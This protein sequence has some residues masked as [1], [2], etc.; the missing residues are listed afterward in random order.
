MSY[1]TTQP[2]ELT[3][4]GRR[5]AGSRLWDGRRECG[6]GSADHRGGSRGR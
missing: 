2:E 4:S 5:P 3:D 1:V 6:G